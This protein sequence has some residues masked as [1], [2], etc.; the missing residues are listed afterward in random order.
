MHFGRLRL[1][2]AHD[3]FFEFFFEH[4]FEGI[5]EG[6]DVGDFGFS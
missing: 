2:V 3:D 6:F 1:E 4:F 5:G